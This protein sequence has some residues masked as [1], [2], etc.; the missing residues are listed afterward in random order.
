MSNS[1][2]EVVMFK[3]GDEVIFTP[4]PE[5]GIKPMNFNA[6]IFQNSELNNDYDSV[7]H[8]LK[9]SNNDVTN[10]ERYTVI[11]VITSNNQF[12]TKDI[13]PSVYLNE[14][15][16]KKINYRIAFKQTENELFMRITFNDYI[17]NKVVYKK[18]NITSIELQD[19]KKKL[20]KVQS[21][22]KK[23]L[24]DYKDKIR[25]FQNDRTKPVNV[26]DFIREVEETME[27]YNN[28]C[29]E[30]YFKLYQLLDAELGLTYET[31]Q[32]INAN[33]I[34]KLNTYRK[35]PM[36]NNYILNKTNGSKTQ[37]KNKGVSTRK[38]HNKPRN[39]RKTRSLP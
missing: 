21:N 2:Q 22:L 3:K 29:E 38:S 14:Y 39:N 5:S 33:T 26:T 19:K 10:L 18:Q 15:I 23:A 7:L 9:L 17:N 36:I 37:S 20:K 4:V 34:N 16:R 11:P 8:Y 30:G 27:N 1:K 31:Q 13:S 24:T 35:Y 12:Y 32:G 25:Y 6:T 28:Q